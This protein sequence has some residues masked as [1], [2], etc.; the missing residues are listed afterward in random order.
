MRQIKTSEKTETKSSAKLTD[1]QN[2]Q[3]PGRSHGNRTE[4]ES[5]GVFEFEKFFNLTCA[6]FSFK[7][8][9]LEYQIMFVFFVVSK[10]IEK[11]RIMNSLTSDFVAGQTNRSETG[12]RR[13]THGWKG[14]RGN[15]IPGRI[16]L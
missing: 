10:E 6:C 7:T 3:L 1:T 11:L 9:A 14:A 8:I 13:S 16:R 2:E 4:P 15:K 5:Q 12:G